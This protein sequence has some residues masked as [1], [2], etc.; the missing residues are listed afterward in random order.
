MDDNTKQGY[1][2]A[3][4]SRLQAASAM[5]DTPQS[6]RS[7]EDTLYSIDNQVTE[8]IYLIKEF[9]LED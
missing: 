3:V 5:V 6:A 7:L 9:L 4:L 8:A 2:K 1:L